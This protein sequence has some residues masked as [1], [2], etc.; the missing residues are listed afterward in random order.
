MTVTIVS[1]IFFNTFLLLLLTSREQFSV[2]VENNNCKNYIRK[3]YLILLFVD[4]S[5]I[6]FREINKLFRATVGASVS[7]L[8]TISNTTIFTLISKIKRK[9]LYRSLRNANALSILI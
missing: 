3:K 8:R 4:L 2:F 9:K 1:E 6:L 7:E 5:S